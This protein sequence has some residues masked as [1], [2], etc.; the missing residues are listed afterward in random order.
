MQI[1]RNPEAEDIF[2]RIEACEDVD[3][4][5]IIAF[6]ARTAAWPMEAGPNVDFDNRLDDI[7]QIAMRKLF[8]INTD[9]ANDAIELYKRAFPPDGDYGLFFKEWG[10]K[11]KC[12]DAM[13]QTETN[14]NE[15]VAK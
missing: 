5:R 12:I 10:E 14:G 15:G 11:R 2:D 13:R 3:A 7:S 9:E 6:T 4:L 8:A 1:L